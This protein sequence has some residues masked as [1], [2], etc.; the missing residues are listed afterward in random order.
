MSDDAALA[1]GLVRDAAALAARMRVAG[2]DTETKTGPSDLVTAADRAAERLVLD[3]LAELRPE[4]G[5]VGEEGSVRDSRSGRTWVIDPVDG[6]YN[7][8][9]GLPWWCCALALRGP[10]DLVLGAVHD[11]TSGRT[12]V[13]GPDLPTERDG[14]RLP[15]LADV[16]LGE[17]CVATYLHP[18]WHD[19][20]VGVLWRRVVGAAATWRSLGSGSMDAVAVAEGRLGVLVQHSVPDWDALPGAGLIRGVGGVVSSIE[21]AGVTWHVAG[22][23]T[24]VAEVRAA[25]GA[26]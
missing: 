13:G 18:P 6:T 1:G 22:A 21:A 15:G 11:P 20:P 5:V 2:L 23:S 4:D 8:V 7:F 12:L 24:A 9:A 10:E 19:G 14:T 3:R 17:T 16:S 25:L 26:R